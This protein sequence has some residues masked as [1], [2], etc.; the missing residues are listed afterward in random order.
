MAKIKIQ[1]LA[2]EKKI[3]LT[4]WIDLLF[5][6]LFML[7]KKIS[8]KPIC[9]YSLLSIQ[10]ERN[11]ICFGIDFKKIELIFDGSWIDFFKI[12]TKI[13]KIVKILNYQILKLCEFV[14]E[15]FKRRKALYM[16][17]L[18]GASGTPPKSTT[19]ARENAL[20]NFNYF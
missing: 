8:K 12:K 13:E 18:V 9:S 1:R 15:N 20:R 5:C 11:S 7:E 19:S 10:H 17:H 3:C 2:L 4:F 14:Q 16:W 6:Y